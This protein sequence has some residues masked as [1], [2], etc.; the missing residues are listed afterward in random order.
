[1]LPNSPANQDLLGFLTV[2]GSTSLG[3]AGG[4]LL[5]NSL[6]RPVEFHSTAQVKP[7]RT[8]EI[9]FGPTLESFL[10]GEQIGQTLTAKT[11]N[12]PRVICVDLPI[13]LE[14]R[15]FVSVPVVLIQTN[16]TPS[17]PLDEVHVRSMGGICHF[18]VNAHHCA[19]RMPERSDQALAES[20]LASISNRI[21]LA[22]PFDR[23]RAAML[24][25]QRVAA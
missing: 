12:P 10:Y 20:F 24:E 23:V 19:V 14:V 6:G 17:I 4:Y 13:L 16:A 15:S 11:K 25:A 7:T 3:L 5:V 18:D 8:Q 2:V 22:E 9:L 1:M 21:D